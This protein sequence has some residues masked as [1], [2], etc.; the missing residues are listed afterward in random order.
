MRQ[1][2]AVFLSGRGSTAQAMFD[3]GYPQEIR[4][5]VSSKENAYGL[6]R[7]ARLGI[8]TLVLPKQINWKVLNVELQRRGIDRIFLL[9]FMKLIPADFLQ[10]WNGRIWNV[11]PSLLPAYPG[12]RSLEKSFTDRAPVGVT[13]HDV[14]VGMDEG[15]RRLQKPVGPMR[16]EWNLADAE[17]RVA[18]TEQ[19][20]IRD[21][22]TR[23]IGIGR[24]QE[25]RGSL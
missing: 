23:T 1:R 21:W 6:K 16:Q 19:R 9:G 10:T 8:P 11:H 7:A 13:I 12:L 24:E 14:T 17:V 20:L 25:S 3:L 15:T 5:V 2:W 18:I 4:L 22:A